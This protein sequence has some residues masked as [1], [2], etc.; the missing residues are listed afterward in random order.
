V[1]LEKDDYAGFLT[2]LGVLAPK[3]LEII[4]AISRSPSDVSNLINTPLMLTLL[5]LVYE[6]EKEIPSEL[7][8]FFKKLFVTMFSRHDK[9]KAGFNRSHHS[10]LSERKLQLFFEVFCFVSMVKGFGRTLNSEQFATAFEKSCAYSNETLAT[11]EG[12]RKDIIKVACL[13]IEEGFDLV[14][15]LHKSIA[16]YF[17]ASFITR[18]SEEKSEKFYKMVRADFGSWSPV[19]DFL[20]RID[21]YRFYKYYVIPTYAEFFR[22]VGSAEKNLT[23]SDD[24]TAFLLQVHPK[25]R[26]EFRVHTGSKEFAQRGW[27][28]FGVNVGY[29]ME[30]HNNLLD[31]LILGLKD[32]LRNVGLADFLERTIFMRQE[33]AP[34][35]I[36]YSVSLK[37]AFNEY[38]TTEL[39]KHVNRYERELWE[40]YLA[41][42]SF[43]SMEDNKLSKLEL[44]FL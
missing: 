10:G 32:D 18:T 8:E 6:S 12:F 44:D 30:L 21:Q 28:P 26:I 19:M 38:G 9:V 27:G 29:S 33:F 24:W 42:C 36:E 11:V 5:V 16:E 31:V 34:D 2:R 22:V 35:Q 37:D 20:E 1:G 41:A 39:L 4:D 43:V 14:T 7:P 13:M 3:R 15:F 25:M 17:A 23:S 40:K